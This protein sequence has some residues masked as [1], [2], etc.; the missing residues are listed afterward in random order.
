MELSTR[1]GLHLGWSPPTDRRLFHGGLVTANY[2]AETPPWSVANFRGLSWRTNPPLA[3][4]VRGDYSTVKYPCNFLRWP[5]PPLR[6][7]L[8]WVRGGHAADFLTTVDFVAD[9]IGPAKN[10]FVGPAADSKNSD[11]GPPRVQ[12]VRRGSAAD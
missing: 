10:I 3:K 6:R 12:Q 1:S 8:T 7:G 11:A 2:S 4:K 9:P 5:S